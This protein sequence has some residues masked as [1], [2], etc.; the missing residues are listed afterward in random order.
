MVFFLEGCLGGFFALFFLRRVFRR[1]LCIF[2]F[3][4]SGFG[5]G[6]L[7]LLFEEGVWAVSLCF[8]FFF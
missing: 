3:L 6:F 7:L 4:F 8:F 5:V 2:L 1:L